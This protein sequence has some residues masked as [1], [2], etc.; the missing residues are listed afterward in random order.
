MASVDAGNDAGLLL[1]VLRHVGCCRWVSWRFERVCDDNLGSA[2]G[3]VRLPSA[4][5]VSSPVRQ[6]RTI[7]IKLF[8]KARTR[9][10]HLWN[11]SL[12]LQ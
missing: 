3:V 9:N 10:T 11:R 2:V 5:A 4:L 1:D 8:Q 6:V 7:N 12:Y